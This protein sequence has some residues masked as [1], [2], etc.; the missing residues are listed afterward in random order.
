MPAAA[1]DRMEVPTRTWAAQQGLKSG[2]GL[3]SYSSVQDGFVYHGHSG[4]VDGGLTEL[5]YLPDS[6]VGYFY[7]INT[8]NGDA[9]MK[10]GKAI[11]AY[12]TRDLRKPPL[13]TVAPLPANASSYAGWYMPNSSRDESSYFAERLVGM[14]HVRI[15][16]GRLLLTSLTGPNRVLVPVAGI[17]FRQL[18]ARLPQ[19]NY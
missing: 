17:Q 15:E 16:D 2:Y 9:A 8:G 6:V 12:I 10:I 1:I 11:R 5:A 18:S 4:A 19:P 13:P 3:G 14:I 7:S